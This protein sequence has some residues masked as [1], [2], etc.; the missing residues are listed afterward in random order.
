MSTCVQCGKPRESFSFALSG[1]LCWACTMKPEVFAGVP[2]APPP[3]A[4]VALE[5]L[6]DHIFKTP[7]WDHQLRAFVR[8]R[9]VTAFALLMEMGTGKSHVAANKMVWLFAHGK[10]TGVLLV[11]PKSLARNWR[12]LELPK[13]MH[14]DVRRHVA[15]YT[16]TPN[17]KQQ[18][19]LEQL[20]KPDP[21]ELK[22]LIMNVEG[23][24]TPRAFAF[25]RKFVL[26][27]QTLMVVDESTKIASPK[28]ACTDRCIKLG[29]RCPYR[30]ILTGQPVPQSPLGV[31]AQ[32]FFLDP[33]ILDGSDFLAFKNRYAEQEKKWLTKPNGTRYEFNAVVGYQYLDDLEARIAPHSFRVLKRDCLDLPEKVYTRRHVELGDEQLRVYRELQSRS[34]AELQTEEREG[35]T[36][37]AVLVLTKLLRLRQV[38]AGFVSLDPEDG[39]PVDVKLVKW[40]D[41]TRIDE[42]AEAWETAGRPKLLVWSYFRPSL[43]KLYERGRELAGEDGAG[44]F[45]GDTKVDARAELVNRFQDPQD[46]LRWLVLNPRSGGHGLTLTAAKLVAYHDRDWSRELRLQ[47]EDRAHR[48]GLKHSVTYLDLLTPGTVDDAITQVYETVGLLA[49]QVTGDWRRWLIETP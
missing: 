45:F 22:V 46:P 25:A 24:H 42:L 23:L 39:D 19:A 15:I 28:A 47:S 14:D 16:G 48:A 35:R 40:L 41:G 29:E 10:I 30:L 38:L 11:L 6:T 8:C 12:D 37:S 49:D 33:A 27:H 32:F 36:V 20:F 43:L 5:P 18:A 1:G 44:L 4:P 7:P 2:P 34:Y 9:D 13:H 21:L 26:A 31:W 17:K 3:P